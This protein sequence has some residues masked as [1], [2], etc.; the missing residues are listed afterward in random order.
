MHQELVPILTSIQMGRQ[1]EQP[2]EISDHMYTL[3]G[4]RL[5]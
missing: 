4:W 3:V 1:E 2:A 5:H